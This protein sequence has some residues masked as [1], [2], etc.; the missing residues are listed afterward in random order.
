[1]PKVFA[2]GRLILA[3]GAFLLAATLGCGGPRTYPV[4]GKIVYANGAEAKELEGGSVEFES[5]QGGMTA[6]GGIGPN[7]SFR[8]GTFKLD[9]GAV[10]GKHRALITPP[11]SR[12][13]DRPSPPVIDPRFQQF[14]TSKL[15]VTIKPEKNEVVLTVER[16]RNQ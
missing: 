12:D 15:E 5:E 13:F 7:G 2:R 11:P 16:P 8:V 10:P 4:E 14:Q 6:R 1:M 3:L 9:D